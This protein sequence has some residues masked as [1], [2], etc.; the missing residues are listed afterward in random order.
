MVEVWKDVQG[1]EGRYRVSN[2]GNVLSL[3]SNKPLKPRRSK[4]GYLTVV[5]YL[6][7]KAKEFKIHRLVAMHFIPNPENKPEVNHKDGNKE[8]NY[9]GNLEWATTKE[10]INHAVKHNLISDRKGQ[11]HNNA[12]LDDSAVLE[13][14]ERLKLK[15]KPAAIARKFGV[16]RVTISNIKWG[17]SWTH[18]TG[19]NRELGQHL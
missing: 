5:L 10:N 9:I 15:E 13:I 4:K 3:V 16:S 8:N 2:F 14:I 17:K 12:K 6:K 11:D 1:Y 18:L 19:V 7:G